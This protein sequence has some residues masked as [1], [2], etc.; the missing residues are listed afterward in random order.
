MYTEPEPDRDSEEFRFELL[1]PH[2]HRAD[3]EAAQEL[4]IG[5]KS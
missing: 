4:W 1:C 5:A 2:G 3:D